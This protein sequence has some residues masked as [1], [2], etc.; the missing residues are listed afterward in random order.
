PQLIVALLSPWVGR[1]AQRIGRRPL[2]L[3]GFAAVPMR[4]ILFA[5][6]T[7]PFLLV[8]VQVLDGIAAAAFTVLTP[9]IIADVARATGRV[10]LSLGI[11]GTAIGIGAALS[12]TLA[13]Y[14]SDRFGTPAAFLALAVVAAAG[15]ALVAALMPETR[16]GGGA[17]ARPKGRGLAGSPALR[18]QPG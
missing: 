17:P 18:T 10:N 16:P 5:A 8:V 12:T 6:V 9:F 11:V 13:G 14:V 7:D 1:S 2:L 3:L 15:V 4:G